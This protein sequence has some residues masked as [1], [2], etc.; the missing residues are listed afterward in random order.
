MKRSSYPRLLLCT[1]AFIYVNCVSFASGAHNI[2]VNGGFE[3]STPPNT[4]APGWTLTDTD[5]LGPL[6]FV[7]TDSAF[8][9]SGTH[10]AALG[11]AFPP[12]P[13]SNGNLKQTLAT[14][15]GGFY[16]LNF[17]LAHDVD[18]APSN[19]F[20]A[21]FNGVPVFTLT[22]NAGA[23]GYINISIA[24][25]FAPTGS[26]L[27]EFRFRDSDDFF[28]LDDVTVN[29]VP[30]LASTIWLAL[31]TLGLLCLVHF[32]GTKRRELLARVA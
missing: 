21:F 31:P 3:S 1:A 14:L 19:S 8:A 20:Q 12:D 15:P 25:L 11:T 29:G 13:P 32:W 9:H 23:F 17:W 26:T 10:Y 24:N 6:S 30:D 2:V 28:R 22:P 4:F 5:P 16:S 27:L 18:V 7:G